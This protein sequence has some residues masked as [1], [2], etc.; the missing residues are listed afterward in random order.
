MHLVCPRRRHSREQVAPGDRKVEE[1]GG[2]YE[3]EVRRPERPDRRQVDKVPACSAPNRHR[4]CST[5]IGLA[6][7]CRVASLT[8]QA[9]S[10]MTPLA[11][12]ADTVQSGTAPALAHRYSEE[13]AART[14]EGRARPRVGAHVR[15]HGGFGPRE[16][17]TQ[18]DPP[19]GVG[20]AAPAHA[21]A[22]LRERQHR[23]RPKASAG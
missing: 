15:C 21:L 8:R 13:R 12:A 1:P 6:H 11:M 3:A 22:V 23:P 9:S 4:G 19:D 14:H 20:R 18:L 16:L 2:P 5:T 7:T 10:G 17:G